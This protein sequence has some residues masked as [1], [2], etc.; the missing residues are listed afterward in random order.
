M[1][2]ELSTNHWLRPNHTPAD[3]AVEAAAELGFKHIQIGTPH[4]SGDLD[5]IVELRKK[6]KLT[7]SVHSPFFAEKGF[8]A[9]PSY[10]NRALLERS[11]EIYIKSLENA[12]FVGAKKMVIH[13]SEPHHEEGIPQLVESLDLLAPKAEKLGITLCLENKFQPSQIGYAENE[14]WGVLS[15]VDHPNVKMCFDTAH[16]AVALG[17]I[18][19]MLNFL[20]E[21][22]PKVAD[23]H[24]V[25]VTNR[26]DCDDHQAPEPDEYYYDSVIKILKDANYKGDLTFEAVYDSDEHILK[27]MKY[28][29]K[30]IKKYKA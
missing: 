11:R 24:L 20:R 4:I 26:I 6:H 7:F 13:A 29:E 19:G 5:K 8:I 28:I 10:K 14:L 9:T 22:A 21:I 23:V 15:E 16:A 30:L 27:G 12:H 17:S 2:V 3:V 25:P 18:T 1:E